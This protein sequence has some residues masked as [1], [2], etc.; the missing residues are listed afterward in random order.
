M[1]PKKAW[2]S[3]RRGHVPVAHLSCL[4]T[5]MLRS[6]RIAQRA[7]RRAQHPRQS[8]VAVTNVVKPKYPTIPIIYADRARIVANKPAGIVAQ[9]NAPSSP[10]SSAEPTTA[11]VD[12]LVHSATFLDVQNRLGLL[13]RPEAVHRL[14]KETTGTWISH[15]VRPHS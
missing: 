1:D 4:R 15:E 12:D 6:L 11:D 5:R 13:Y 7:Q 2:G 3:V 14:D 10:S 9:P 8:V